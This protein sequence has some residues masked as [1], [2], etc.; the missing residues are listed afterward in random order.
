MAKKQKEKIEVAQGDRLKTPK[1]QPNGRPFK[2]GQ[3]GNPGGRPKGLAV[4]VREKTGDGTQ[5]VNVM[6]GIAQGKLLVEKRPPS[7]RDRIQAVEWL[8]DRGFGSSPQFAVTVN[9]EVSVDTT[10]QPE[11]LSVP[12]LKA[13]LEELRSRPET[14]GRPA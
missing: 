14:N 7:H 13:R 3:S 12:Q 8:A 4:L 10:K 1:K 5:L 2:P 11:E 6:A 9:N